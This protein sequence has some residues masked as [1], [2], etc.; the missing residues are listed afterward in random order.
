MRKDFL[1][2]VYELVKKAKLSGKSLIETQEILKKY[3]RKQGF[4]RG[5]T[6]YC[7]LD[8]NYEIWGK[9]NMSWPNA[10][11]TGPRYEV[12][13]PLTQKPVPIPNRG[14]RWKEE[15]FLNALKGEEFILPD[16]SM[17]KGRIWFANNDSTQP[18]S[19]TYLKEVESFLLRSIISQKSDGSITLENLGLSDTVNYPKPVKL[20]EYLLYSTSLINGY[21]LDYF[22]GSGTT[23]HSVQKLNNQ[24]N[25]KRKCILIEQGS[26]VN[27]VIIPR[28]KKVAYSFDWKE[29]KPENGSMNGL[30]VFIKYQRLEQYEEAL[31][32]ISFTAGKEAQQ[33]ALEFDQYVPKYMLEFETRNSRTLVNT[34]AMKDPWDYKLKVWDG[35][36]YDTEQAVDLV[37]TFN[38]L[39]G[40]HMQKYLT[41]EINGR[42]YQFVYGHNN[43]NKNI[44]VLWRNVKN[45]KLE[46]YKKD[47]EALKEELKNYS[48]DLL[49]INDQAHI[50][51]YQPVE[52][53][54]KNK[55]LP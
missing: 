9:I 35:F 54:F 17:M 40:L 34:E 27:S 5:I 6:L 21:F 13:N 37:E 46:D 42:R 33:K 2:E 49:Y 50:E 31:E 18:S 38:Y 3:Y 20:I 25:E 32:N 47:G 4:D 45:W 22:S 36:T 10:K 1:E 15:T 51:G 41:K 14:W 39:I 8:K 44:L 30:G 11:T 16:G 43:A 52:E 55:M 23:F 29:G 26:Y 19:I 7:E 12:I 24:D 48:Y 28:I 53:V